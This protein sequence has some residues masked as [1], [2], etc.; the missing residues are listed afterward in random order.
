MLNASRMRLSPSEMRLSMRVTLG[1]IKGNDR[2]PEGPVS[3]Y[4]NALVKYTNTDTRVI[5]DKFSKNHNRSALYTATLGGTPDKKGWGQR[6]FDLLDKEDGT[7]LKAFLEDHLPPKGDSQVMVMSKYN[8]VHIMI[9]LKKDEHTGNFVIFKI[10]GKQGEFDGVNGRTAGFDEVVLQMLDGIVFNI[11]P[12]I[13]PDGTTH[14]LIQAELALGLVGTN[15]ECVCKMVHRMWSNGDASSR[16]RVLDQLKL[17]VFSASV[18]NPPSG[19]ESASVRPISL[20]NIRKII[21]FCAEKSTKFQK[22]NYRHYTEEFSAYVMDIEEVYRQWGP[23][24]G[25]E[26]LIAVVQTPLQ[27]PSGHADPP[28]TVTKTKFKGVYSDRYACLFPTNGPILVVLTSGDGGKPKAVVVTNQ[29]A[30]GKCE[31]YTHTLF[32]PFPYPEYEGGVGYEGSVKWTAANQVNH[33]YDRFPKLK[34]DS[35]VKSDNHT[36]FTVQGKSFKIPTWLYHTKYSVEFLCIDLCM[37]GA[38]QY[39]LLYKYNQFLEPSQRIDTAIFMGITASAD[40]DPMYD[41]FLQWLHTDEHLTSEQKVYLNIKLPS[42]VDVWDKDALSQYMKI[43]CSQIRLGHEP[44]IFDIRPLYKFV[45]EREKIE[46]KD[47]RESRGMSRCGPRVMKTA[48]QRSVSKFKLTALNLAHGLFGDACKTPENLGWAL[49]RFSERECQRLGNLLINGRELR[50]EDKAALTTLFRAQSDELREMY[51]S[52]PTLFERMPDEQCQ[53][54]PA[55]Q[56]KKPESP[57]I[58]VDEDETQAPEDYCDQMQQMPQ[59]REIGDIRQ[60]CLRA[61]VARMESRADSSMGVQNDPQPAQ[62]VLECDSP[63]LSHVRNPPS[64]PPIIEASASTNS[65]TEPQSGKVKLSAWSLL[66]EE[67][68]DYVNM[69]PGIPI[70]ISKTSRFVHVPPPLPTEFAEL[71]TQTYRELAAAKAALDL[72]KARLEAAEAAERLHKAEAAYKQRDKRQAPD[73]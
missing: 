34:P 57:P 28:F 12:G 49:M 73:P 72:A 23:H 60:E 22:P 15:F 53:P 21:R 58:V 17:Y 24:T 5:Y 56:P 8:G 42:K 33:Y 63:I 13:F 1:G 64:L 41:T 16:R 18:Y 26:G 67:E 11:P 45:A 47:L 2:V 32:Q 7:V 31:Y 43:N 51:K 25:A 37:P 3:E 48:D 14:I 36:I 65:T 20:A 50:R 54:T 27:S 19:L 55:T 4:Y 66:I 6:T 40:F 39:Y 46:L 68:D 61:A 71:T 38:G 59:T 29:V 44:P 62:S 69:G 52:E 30:Q 9:I 70:T 10:V 35:V